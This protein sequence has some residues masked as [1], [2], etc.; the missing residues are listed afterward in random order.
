MKETWGESGIA[1]KYLISSLGRVWSK[2]SKKCISQRKDPN[3][4]PFV[5]VY[6]NSKRKS[7]RVH[8]LV[9]DCFLGER[10]FKKVINHKDGNPSNNNV[11][12]LE[13]V[14]QSYNTKHAIENG[15]RK[16]NTQ[17]NGERCRNAKLNN[18]QV[19]EIRK[20]LLLGYGCM[21][22]GKIFSVNR[23]TILAIKNRFTW[24]HI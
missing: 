24:K 21:E 6:V 23:N 7:L 12:N 18:K 2:H 20:K 13:Y 11:N 16:Y 19:L 9:A 3:N 10:P 17:A 8:V 22:L 14:T 5:S 4:Y 15:K 1:P